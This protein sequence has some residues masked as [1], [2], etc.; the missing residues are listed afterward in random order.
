M[1]ALIG[2]ELET[3]ISEPDALTTRPPRFRAR[4]A[5]HKRLG[6]TVVHLPSDQQ[7]FYD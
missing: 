2:V 3:L 6:F 5:D 1:M 7:S 4:R